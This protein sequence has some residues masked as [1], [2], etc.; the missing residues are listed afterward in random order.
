V[1]GNESPLAVDVG[2]DGAHEGVVD[3]GEVLCEERDRGA[4]VVEV[5][6]EVEDD[7]AG[8][9]GGFAPVWRGG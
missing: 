7:E 1:N 4:H 8:V 3:V 5:H 2:D 6:A 9:G